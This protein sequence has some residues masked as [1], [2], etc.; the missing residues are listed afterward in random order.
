MITNYLYM[1]LS[2][3]RS[4]TSQQINAIE[5]LEEPLI[6]KTGNSSQRLVV[7]TKRRSRKGRE[8]FE[9]IHRLAKR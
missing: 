1:I 8:F 6:C 9:S 2:F 7:S 5:E 4:S 3:D